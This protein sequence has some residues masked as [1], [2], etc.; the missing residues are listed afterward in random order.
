MIKRAPLALLA[1][2]ALSLPA[3]AEDVTGTW[4]AEFDTVRGLQKYTFALKQDDTGLSGKARVELDGETR[5]IDLQEA[6]VDGDTVSF[7]EV[8]DLQG[9]ELRITIGGKQLNLRTADKA[10]AYKQW[11]ELMVAADQLPQLGVNPAALDLSARFLEWTEKHRPSTSYRWFRNYL[12]KFAK[13][14]PVDIRTADLK[15][16]HLTRWVE[17]MVN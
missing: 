3:L 5:E 10:N 14:L 6:K 12:C 13:S 15:P 16:F 4:K 11:H 2:A 7:V 9:N 17:S 1:L 8:L